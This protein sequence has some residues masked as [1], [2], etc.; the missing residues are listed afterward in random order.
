MAEEKKDWVTPV[1]I[2]AGV[3]GIGAGVY[4]LMKKPKGVDPGDTVI[5][6]FAF[7][8]LGSGGTYVIQLSL[9]N[10]LISQWFDRIEGLTW[11]AEIELPS[12]DNYTFDLECPL[13]E[14]IKAQVYDAEALI[15]T[16]QMG[17]REY[18]IKVVAKD[19]VR[20]RKA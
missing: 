20:V 16:P 7:D 19:A 9:G 12:P 17:D 1:A 18:L 15:R 4:F 10:I 2:G 6:R 14:A 8:Y 5:A 11:S 3:V 13:P